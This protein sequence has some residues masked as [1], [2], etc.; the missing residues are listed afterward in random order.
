MPAQP[1]DRKRNDLFTLR[2]DAI[3]PDQI[4]VLRVSDLPAPAQEQGPPSAKRIDVRTIRIL[5]A[6]W[7]QAPRQDEW[8][9][10]GAFG[11][12]LKQIAPDFKPSDYGYKNLG[13][14]IRALPNF[15]ELRQRGESVQD[16]RFIDGHSSRL[17]DTVR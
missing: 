14:L 9:F 8:L 10:L 7:R 4:I 6:A 12:Q 17:K 11:H 2:R 16:V 5:E 13:S 3:K 15:F 1:L